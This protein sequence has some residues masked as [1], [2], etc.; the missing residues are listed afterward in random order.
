MEPWSEELK[1]STA[2]DLFKHCKTFRPDLRSTGEH[3]V[4]DLDVEAHKRVLSVA[5][6]VVL[7]AGIPTAAALHLIEEICHHLRDTRQC[8]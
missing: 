5:S 3:L 6:H 8:E 1:M 2:C 4:V 7:H